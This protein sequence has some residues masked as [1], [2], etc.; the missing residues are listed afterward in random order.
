MHAIRKQRKFYSSPDSTRPAT[1]GESGLEKAERRL[2]P[3][4]ASRKSVPNMPCS[5]PGSVS[6]E[7]CHKTEHLASSDPWDAVKVPSLQ[8]CAGSG[9][10]QSRR[11]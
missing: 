5:S 8:W 11:R 7:T 9:G 3:R 10:Q 6:D 1:V 2:Q 4:K